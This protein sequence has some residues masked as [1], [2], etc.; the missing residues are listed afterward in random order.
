MKKI[1]IATI[2]AV[3]IFSGCADKNQVNKN[4]EKPKDSSV[5]SNNLPKLPQ[6]DQGD[7]AKTPKELEK[8]C[9][10]SKGEWKEMP[11]PCVGTCA[12]ERAVKKGEE[13]FCVQVVAPG[14]DCGEGKCWDGNTCEAL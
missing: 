3:L 11:N 4:I 2:F 12:Y 7:Q 13:I 9:T 6:P 8:L 1:F 10:A 14:C 5:D